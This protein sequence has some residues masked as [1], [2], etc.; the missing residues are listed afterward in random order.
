MGPTDDPEQ[1]THRFS[2]GTLADVSW[3]DVL[4]R[5]MSWSWQATTTFRQRAG[6]TSSWDELDRRLPTP[7]PRRTKT[8][9]IAFSPQA[10]GTQ[11][12]LAFLPN[13]SY[14]VVSD[15]QVWR[16]RRWQAPRCAERMHTA[17]QDGSKCIVAQ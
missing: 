16:Y 8:G 15:L 7:K 10:S 11:G 2:Y 3:P 12:A 1:G 9:A 17:L 4:N 13:D 14:S 5:V 6:M